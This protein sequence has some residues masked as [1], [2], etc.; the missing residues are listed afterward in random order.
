MRIY[1]LYLF[2]RFAAVSHRN[3]T[4]QRATNTAAHAGQAGT[5]YRLSYNVLHYCATTVLQY[6]YYQSTERPHKE[7]RTTPRRSCL[8]LCRSSYSLHG[9]DELLLLFTCSC[10]FLYIYVQW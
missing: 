10:F 1:L 5:S 6:V 2:R 7:A 8:A 4:L 9:D 3:I